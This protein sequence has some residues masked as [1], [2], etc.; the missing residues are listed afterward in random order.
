MWQKVSEKQMHYVRW[1]LEIGWLILIF[2]MFYDPIAHYLTDPND[3]H[4]LLSPFRIKKELGYVQ[5]QNFCNDLAPYDMGA[6]IFWGMLV[7]LGTFMLIVFGHKAWRRICPLM[8]LSQIPRALG[9]QRRCRVVDPLTN[10][11]RS[12]PVAIAKSSWLGRNFLYVQ[13][14]L[15]FLGLNVSLLFVNSDRLALGGFLCMTILAVITVGFLY[16]GK[17]WCQYFCPMAPVQHIYTGPLEE[18]L[19]RETSC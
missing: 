8:F 5:F 1:L 2:P 16:A 7:P 6:R 10:T 18:L 15:L 9:W 17:S 12:E 3:P 4:M 13:F 11:M 14:G 19:L